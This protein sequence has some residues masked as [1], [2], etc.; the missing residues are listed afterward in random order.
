[1]NL[2]VGSGAGPYD[3]RPRATVCLS[4]DVPKFHVSQDVIKG[5]AHH[6]PFRSKQ[7][8]TTFCFNVLE[9]VSNPHKV[10]SELIRVSHR[11]I[12]RQDSIFNLANYATPEH[13]WFQLPNLHFLPYHRTSIGILFSKSLRFFL[14]HFHYKLLINFFLPPHQQYSLIILL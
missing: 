4:F 9:H 1:M 13:L 10:I 11:V 12:I 7:F 14:L 8:D 2:D 3:W 6:L 5:D